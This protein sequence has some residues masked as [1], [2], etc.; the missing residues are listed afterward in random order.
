MDGFSG[1]NQ[2]N[3]ASTDQEN[4]TFIYPWGTF[5]YKSLPFGL[6]KARATFQ[7]VMFYDF[8]NIR[9]NVQPYLDDL[10][11]HSHKHEDFPNHLQQIFLH[12]RQYNIWLNLYKCVFYIKNGWI[13]GFIFSKDIILL[14]QIK[15]KA[16][17]N[18]STPSFFHQL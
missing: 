15:V 17:V 7:R 18:L 13:L 1:Y 11:T 5:V 3:I 8:H 10:P 9:N 4:T 6:K 12:F 16:I 2:I 14:D